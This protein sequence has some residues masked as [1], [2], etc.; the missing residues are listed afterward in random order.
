MKH[1]RVCL[2]IRKHFFAVGVTEHWSRLP[3]EFVDSP[4]LEILKSC[5]DM[6]LGNQLW[7]ALLEQGLRPDDLQRSLP[8]STSL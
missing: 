1:K 4:S 6:V 7:V 8:T 5:L 2:N 3:G